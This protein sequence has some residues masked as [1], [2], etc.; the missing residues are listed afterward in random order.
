MSS[1]NRIMIC[2]L[3]GFQSSCEERLFLHFKERHLA[4]KSAF[5]SDAKLDSHALR[6][7]DNNQALVEL[8][9]SNNTSDDEPFG[10]CP[11]EFCMEQFDWQ[12]LED[13]LESHEVEDME[14]L[15]SEPCTIG[16]E[17]GNLFAECPVDSC[18]KRVNLPALDRSVHPLLAEVNGTSTYNGA[19]AAHV[20]LGADNEREYNSPYSNPED[21]ASSYGG[22]GPVP[23]PSSNGHQTTIDRFFGRKGVVKTNGSESVL[24]GEKTRLG[25]AELGKHA[26]EDQMPDSLVAMLKKGKYTSAEGIVP[27]LARLLEHCSST[28][29]AYL[30][31]P[32]VQHISK[33]RG[34][35]GF[36]GYRNIQ[37]LSSYIVG[38]HAEGTEKL[39]GQIPSIFQIQEFIENAWD[40]NINASGRIETG[41]IRGT[42]KYIG[43]PE[44]QAMFQSLKIPCDAEDFKL[45]EKGASE[46]ALVASIQKYFESVPFNADDKVRRTNLPPIYFQ[47]RGHSLT[48]VGL[49]RRVSGS[50]KL[51]VFDPMYHD[52]KV[53]TR[54]VGGAKEDHSKLL[55]P[56]LWHPDATLNL[57]RRGNKYLRRF[58]AFEIL[59]LAPKSS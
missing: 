28:E 23:T 30:C 50:L 12:A 46:T 2:R 6:D 3:C 58:S 33:L 29:Y 8:H 45:E 14:V 43:T 13:H 27:V 38:A 9:A 5:A 44:A 11:H 15:I 16:S 49:E 40:M 1:S 47:H 4:G 53:L 54:L 59:K 26:Y 37:M 17:N 24:V 32:A 25:V 56:V 42:R 34:E 52:P 21:V 55:T 18:A 35:G 39:G 7:R 22:H 51:L 36:C 20:V 57:Y 48:I 10:Q 41:G 31:H 19:T